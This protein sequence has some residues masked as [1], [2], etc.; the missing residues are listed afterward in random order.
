M[1]RSDREMACVQCGQS[2][3]FTAGEQDFY[4]QNQLQEPRR[5][6]DCR[7]K[8]GA[9]SPRDNNGPRDHN[10]A[11]QQPSRFD[12][13]RTQQPAMTSHAHYGRGGNT[14]APSA[15][16]GQFRR[17]TAQPQFR[18]AAADDPN[19]Y[20][21]PGF[22]DS[23]Q[24]QIDYSGLPKD[25]EADDQA[26]MLG[27]NPPSFARPQTP[28]PRPTRNGHPRGMNGR[29]PDR[30][31]TD[32]DAYRSPGFTQAQGQGQGQAQ[33]SSRKSRQQ[34][35]RFETQ[36]AECGAPAVVP[37]QPAEDRPAFCK[38]C[39]QIKKPLLNL[40]PGKTPSPVEPTAAVA[41]DAAQPADVAPPS[42]AA[43]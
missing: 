25:D 23:Y 13:P 10:R 20:R 21:S 19:G 22:Q 26:A 38:P 24:H 15:G 36:C 27:L 32:P 6:K 43:V 5:C 8:R 3:K 9:S 12:A 35:P 42:D 33:G 14:Q 7:G 2:F 31:G 1:E 40:G 39:Y 34:R 29:Q 11:P 28:A 30:S 37:F 4:Q 41:L 17:R 16:G 18:P